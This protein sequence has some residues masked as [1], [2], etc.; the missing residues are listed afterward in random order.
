MGLTSSKLADV[1]ISPYFH[2]ALRLF[3]E[4]H[5]AKV[6]V[7]MRH[8]ID[9]AVAMYHKLQ[10]ERMEPIIN[11]SLEDYTLSSQVE[12]NAVVRNLTGKMQGEIGEDHL[13]IAKHVMEHVLI[14]V[15]DQLADSIQRFETF[16]R[17]SNNIACHKV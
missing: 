4:H 15:S 14:G 5:K 17:F 8:P 16:F 11:M 7:M 2:H 3:H 10:Y 12:N 9:R 6:F 13:S 1:I